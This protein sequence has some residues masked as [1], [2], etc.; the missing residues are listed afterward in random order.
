M[1]DPCPDDTV[2]APQSFE[3]ALGELQA[4]THRL[5]DGSQGLEA[6]LAEFER[7]VRLLRTCY[8]LLE[9]AEQRIEQLVGIDADGQTQT[10]PFDAA[11]TAAQPGQTAGKRR[12]PATRKS[13]AE[14]GFGSD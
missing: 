14:I 6:S 10:A 7:G 8:Q 5:E 12:G 3:E 1:P 13:Q 11:A 2:A 4:I 9:S